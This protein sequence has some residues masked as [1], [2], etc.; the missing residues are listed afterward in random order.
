MAILT[1]LLFQ[2][3]PMNIYP[4]N[5]VFLNFFH[6]LLMMFSVPEFHL[7]VPVLFFL[8]ATISGIIFLISPSESS[9]L[10][11]RNTLMYVSFFVL[12]QPYSATQAGLVLRAILLPQF[13]ELLGLQ[14]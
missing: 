1:V 14:L 10:V 3:K 4:F 9:L 7:K 12:R 11:Y 8:M 6:Q 5:Y 2:N 13:P